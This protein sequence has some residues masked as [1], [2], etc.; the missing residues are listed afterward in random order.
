M[1]Q[2]A[3]GFFATRYL[4]QD[5]APGIEPRIKEHAHCLARTASGRLRLALAS[6]HFV[7]SDKLAAPT[8]GFCY[9][10][11]WTRQV[12]VMAGDFN[13]RRCLSRRETIDCDVLPFW[14]VLT[15]QGGFRD[16]VFDRHGDSDDSLEAQ[17]PNGRRIDYVFVC[18]RVNKASHDV[19][20]AARKGDP[21]FYSDHRLLWALAGPPTW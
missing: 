13:N 4:A 14:H 9:K 20:Y 6:I 7:T 16:A 12:W 1:I 10:G 3:G 18:G 8:M 19:D 21:G 5:A 17:T 15:A 11:K 2:D